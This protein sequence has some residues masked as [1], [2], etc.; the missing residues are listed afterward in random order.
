[1]KD[2]NCDIC[3]AP[4]E[5]TKSIGTKESGKKFRQTW[6]KCPI[7]GYEVKIV[8]DGTYFNEMTPINAIN[9]V[10]KMFKEQEQNNQ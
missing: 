1:M 4:M 9:D 2:Q 7:C 8:G 5:E 3:T 10:N 6:F